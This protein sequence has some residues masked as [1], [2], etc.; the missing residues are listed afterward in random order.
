VRRY[1]PKAPLWLLFS[2][3]LT[4]CTI[5][6]VVVE[7][8]APPP[9]QA[10]PGAA[11]TH[12]AQVKPTANPPLK[13]EPQTQGNASPPA[14]VQSQ[15][16]APAPPELTPIE[17]LPPVAILVSADIPAYTRVSSELRKRLGQRA[18]VYNLNGDPGEARKAVA[19]IQSAAYEQVVAVGLVAARASRELSGKQVV[20]CQVFNYADDDL[21]SSWM[22]GIT[23]LP[24]LADVFRV[25]RELD[26]RLREV[27][28]I[29]GANK[30]SLV[31]DASQA[32]GIYGI[33]L[34][35]RQVG[36]DKEMLYTFKEL[37][38][39]V[40]GFWL[41]PDNR[42]LSTGVIRAMMSYG[43]RQ[44]KEMLVFSPALLKLGGLMSVQGDE[45][46]VALQ[47]LERLQQAYGQPEIPGPDVIP[48]SDMRVQINAGMAHRLGLVIPVQYK[49]LAY[50]P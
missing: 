18:K 43:V 32:A 14:A 5:T 37:I 25:W 16:A 22:K 38:S 27:A 33:E 6:N 8:S 50:E 15:S 49:P 29:T 4:G 36:S 28:V 11:A 44:G 1:L 46:G 19:Q 21:T 2:A 24:R 13:S 23:M 34:I 20:F 40:Q 10:K 26:P 48:L 42:V 9:P 45:T 30:E 41:L 17:V 12:K 7:H 47:V 35:H 39:E 3:L 31:R